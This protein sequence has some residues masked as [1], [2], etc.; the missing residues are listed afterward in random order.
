SRS[1]GASGSA[2]TGDDS[3][4][5][6]GDG[7]SDDGKLTGKAFHEV[8]K[9]VSA[10]ERKLAKLEERKTAIE[11]KMAD[12]DPSDFM[13]LDKLNAKLNAVGTQSSALEEEW[14]ELSERIEE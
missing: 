14:M 11:Q 7:A 3:G 4:S 6:G 5:A 12:H 2:S 9:R 8:T 13:G 10:I 1:S